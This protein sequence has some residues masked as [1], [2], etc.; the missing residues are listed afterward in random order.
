M[1]CA[2]GFLSILI[3]LIFSGSSTIA[4][5]EPKGVLDRK[6]SIQANNWSLM[7]VARHVEKQEGI[8]TKILLQSAI[9]DR[10][11]PNIQVDNKSLGIL[12]RGLRESANVEILIVD[13]RM[14]AK[15]LPDHPDKKAGDEKLFTNITQI[16][17]VN[18]QNGAPRKD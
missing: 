6:V 18:G 9:A 10:V 17:I 7:K 5:A 11:V 3:L 1:N 2:N 16:R 4:I 12:L 8:N 13:E 14:G 15:R